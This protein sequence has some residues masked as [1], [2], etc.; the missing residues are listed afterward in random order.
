MYKSYYVKMTSCVKGELIEFFFT[1]LEEMY[2]SLLTEDEYAQYCDNIN[3]VKRSLCHDRAIG[4]I[5]EDGVWYAVFDNNGVDMN[6]VQTS[7]RRF[8]PSFTNSEIDTFKAPQGTSYVLNAKDTP[9]DGSMIQYWK[10]HQHANSKINLNNK[11]FRCPSCGKTVKTSDLHGAH[12]IKTTQPNGTLYIT[13]TCDSCNTSKINRIFKVDT[14][15][16][17]EAPK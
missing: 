17:V 16:L 5:T 11:T 9:S 14:I 6:N 8:A 3:S 7:V 2:L 1:G 4:T 13:P 12:V 10:E 15:E